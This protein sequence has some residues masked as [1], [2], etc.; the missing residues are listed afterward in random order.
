MFDNLIIDISFTFHILEG[1]KVC[2]ISSKIVG[3][4]SQIL[5]LIRLMLGELFNMSCILIIFLGLQPCTMTNGSI[6]HGDCVN[7]NYQS[8][9]M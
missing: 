2:F 7:H 9:N 6:K 4:F 5:F 1:I 3:Y 8:Q